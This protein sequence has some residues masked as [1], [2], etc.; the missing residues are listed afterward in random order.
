MKFP[1][2][3]DGNQKLLALDPGYDQFWVLSVQYYLFPGIGNSDYNNLIG[4]GGYS[5]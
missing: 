3:M 4:F 2:S 5:E 1:S